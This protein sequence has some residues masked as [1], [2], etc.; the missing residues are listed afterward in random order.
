MKKYKYDVYLQTKRD[1]PAEKYEYISDYILYNGEPNGEYDDN[2]DNLEDMYY[3]FM[4]LFN[5]NHFV[6]VHY[7]LQEETI[8]INEN[9]TELFK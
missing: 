3:Y 5:G 7:E 6:I 9:Q 8:T 2:K 1:S 4:D